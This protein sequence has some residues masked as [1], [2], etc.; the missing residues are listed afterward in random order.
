VLTARVS[1]SAR[2]YNNDRTVQ[3]YQQVLDRI[4][5]V[6]GV[7]AAGAS[8]WLPV[9]DAGGLWGFMPEGRTYGPGSGNPANQ[10]AAVPQQATPGYFAASGI[11]VLEGR[12]FT[13]ADREG[14]P[15][16][17]II[18]AEM[19][20]QIWPGENALGKRFRIGGNDE[21]PLMT[22]VGIVHDIR[23]RGFADTP[24]PTMYVPFAQTGKT[25]YVMPRAMA[26]I[27]RTT[28]DPFSVASAV[29]SAVHSLDPSAP[30]SEIRSMEQV[31]GSSI[32]TRKFST[33]LLTVFSLLALLL[34]GIGTYGVIAYGVAQRTYEIGVR[35]ALGAE[36]G[37]VVRLVMSEGLRM[38]AVGIGVGLVASVL[39]ARSIRSMLV[40]IPQIDTVSL[41]T[42]T[43]A[44]LLVA[45]LATLIPARR[46]LRVSPTE[47]LRGG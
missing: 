47:A 44:L 9:V 2:E 20:R 6:P 8:G 19:A 5:A 7:T 16:V 38:C 4:R 41:V 21:L 37:S 12:E 33:S 35:M 45:V 10:P 15:Y 14:A 24:E 13:D 46:A 43:L 26:L 30:V 36:Q 29:K 32:S 28:G 31:V 18:S 34:A 3:F 22:I 27:V 11:R 42:T 39:L 17:A 1:I 25:S 23:A 40:D